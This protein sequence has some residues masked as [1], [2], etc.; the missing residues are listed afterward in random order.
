MSDLE[1]W[2]ELILAVTAAF[3]CG[4]AVLALLFTLFPV[5]FGAGGA[6]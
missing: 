2:I 1:F 6:A 4:V 5:L 3:L